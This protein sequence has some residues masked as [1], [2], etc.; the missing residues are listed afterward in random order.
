MFAKHVNKDLSAYCHS[1]L[2]PEDSRRVAEHLIGCPRCRT[3]FDEIKL[4]IRLAEQLP[5]VTA[6]DSLWAE[7]E[8]LLAQAD[9]PPAQPLKRSWMSPLMQSRFAAVAA[10]LLLVVGLG[11]FWLSRREALPFWVVARLAGDPR[12]GST[13]FGEK[14]KLGVGEWLETDGGSRARIDVSGIGQ[15]EI[16]ENTRV[17]LVGT[18]PT[19]HR[20]ELAR[21]KMSAHIW[22]P[23]RLFFV[24]TPSGVAADLGCSYTLEVN[25]AGGSLLR[26][27][28]GWVELQLKDRA[29]IVPAGAACA[30]KP[31]VGPGTPYFEDASERFRATLTKFDFDSTADVSAAL[32]ILLAEARVRDTLTLWHLFAR[33]KGADRERLYNRLVVLVPPPDGVTRAGVLNLNERELQLWKAKMEQSWSGDSGLRKVWIKADTAKPGKK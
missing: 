4:G 17:R 18:K 10:V 1:E 3:E 22:A 12:I 25:D 14:G 16:D 27:T 11:L 6:P 29:S 15:V 5:Q 28:T 8:P 23:P 13:R 26:V 20:L 24:D 7:L 19:E 9:R 21:G 2:S 31:G 33:V 30:T 32:G